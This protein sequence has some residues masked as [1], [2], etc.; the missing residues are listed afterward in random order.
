MLA[1]YHPR[2]IDPLWEVMDVPE[3]DNPDH[4]DYEVCA[5]NLLPATGARNAGS[6]RVEGCSSAVVMFA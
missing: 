1:W 3:H 4:G 5:E 2:G 6:E